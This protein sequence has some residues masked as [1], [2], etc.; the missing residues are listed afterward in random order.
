MFKSMMKV[1]AAGVCTASLGACFQVQN[2]GPVSDA[3][4][5]VA[6]L[7]DQSNILYE[8][9]TWSAEALVALVGEQHWENYGARGRLL[10]LRQVSMNADNI[11][12]GALY[13]VTANGGY[14]A[15]LD[16]DLYEDAVHTPML[17]TLHAI[18][19]G[20]QL[21]TMESVVSPASEMGYQWI[22]STYEFSDDLSV[23][24]ELDH[25]AREFLDDVNGDG[26]VDMVDML[27]FNRMLHEDM[28]RWHSSWMDELAAAIA[29]GG[30]DLEVEDI[31]HAAMDGGGGGHG[32]G[33]HHDDDEPDGHMGH[34]DEMETD[35]NDG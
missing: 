18:M 20:E 11:D 17:G 9:K 22:K 30:T 35:R 13:L 32:P 3:Q 25:V 23:I 31:A 15:D 8:G 5:T 21:L 1:I 26:Q 7:R 12:P 28:Y 16:G 27:A 24:S 29:A 19:P 14:N 6:P 34:G 10:L 4:V 2:F 33:G